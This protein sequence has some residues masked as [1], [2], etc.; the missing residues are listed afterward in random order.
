[1][2]VP[3]GD[4]HREPRERACC[5]QQPPSVG[6]VLAESYRPREAVRGRE[7]EPVDFFFRKKPFPCTCTARS[8][9]SR[10]RAAPSRWPGRS[11]AG[12]PERGALGLPPP[13]LWL[14]ALKG[15]IPIAN[16]TDDSTFSSSEHFP[17]TYSETHDFHQLLFCSFLK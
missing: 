13:E 16:Q 2:G 7:R 10:Q 17:S 4:L 14:R 8:R 9:L 6:C 1:M 15:E 11:A 5:G 12:L 3:G